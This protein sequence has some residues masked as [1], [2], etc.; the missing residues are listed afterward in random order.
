MQGNLTLLIPASIYKL[1]KLVN[2]RHD[3]VQLTN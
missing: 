1:K 2:F 3:W